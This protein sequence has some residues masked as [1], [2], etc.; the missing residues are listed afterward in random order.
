MNGDSEIYI[1]FVLEGT[2]ARLTTT[3][4]S[5]WTPGTAIANAVFNGTRKGN[6]ISAT[7]SV[8]VNDDNPTIDFTVPGHSVN[9][10]VMKECSIVLIAQYTGVSPAEGEVN[11]TVSVFVTYG[12]P[13]GDKIFG[14]AEDDVFEYVIDPVINPISVTWGCSTKEGLKVT[15]IDALFAGPLYVRISFD[16]WEDDVIFGDAYVY[17]DAG[18][19]NLYDTDTWK[20]TRKN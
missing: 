19:T 15:G 20:T 18:L 10:I 2:K 13:G 17:T 16:R 3:D 12:L 6:P 1:D 5:T 8:D 14:F 7:L 4:L 9:A 11:A